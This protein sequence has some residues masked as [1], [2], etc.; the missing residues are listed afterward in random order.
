MP[1]SKPSP[2]AQGVAA[3]LLTP[4]FLGVAP[5][6]GKL[7]ILEGVDP[8]TVAA[9]R[10]VIAVTLLWLIYAVFFRRYF[11]IYPAGMLGCVVVG[12]VNGIGSL[13][14]YG[15]LGLLDASVA[16]LLNGMYIIFAV[17]LAH[18][19]GERIDRRMAL[20]IGLA[21]FGI[22]LITG[23][24]AAPVNW[25]GVG[26]ML[27]NALMFAGSVILSQYVLY[28]MPSH[29]ATLYIL[30]TMAI[31]VVMAWTAVGT[32]PAL[33][34][35]EAAGVPLLLLGITTALSR[36]AMFAAVQVFGSL[37]TAVMAVAEI[38]V[39]LV[40]AFF[41]LDDRLTV[42]QWLGV[43]LLIGSL[44]LIRARDLMPRNFNLSTLLVRD[45]ASVQFQRIAFHRAFGTR[46][47]DNEYGSMSAVTTSELQAI[48]RMMGVKASP[49]DPF[50][51]RRTMVMSVN[52]LN[53][54]L[55]AGESTEDT[56]RP[57]TDK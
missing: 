8:F 31:V 57:D 14:F 1:V 51:M 32:T 23:L 18:I 9:I 54:F 39:A 52:D 33:P 30:T 16:Q 11:F 49:V 46:E 56:S 21:L 47:L 7:A 6:F 41:V 17:L 29:T 43:A 55:K 36:I 10:T 42:P 12:V 45:V 38:A 50:P 53:E 26:L 28:E 25:L 19:G 22:V 48:G 5:V 37:R 4:L 20:R 40:L 44:L 2:R 27:A 15:G 3:A 35:L 24:S 13:F 34:V